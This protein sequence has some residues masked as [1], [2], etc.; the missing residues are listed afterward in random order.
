M[1]QNNPVTLAFGLLLMALFLVLLFVF[2]VRQT[3]VAV[4][5]TFGKA[6]RPITEPGLNFKWPW[7]IQKVTKLD[8]RVQNFEGKFE[9]TLTADGR[10]LLIMVYVGWTIAD[11]GLFYSRFAGGSITEAERTLEGLVRSAKNAAVGRQPFAA[12]ISTEG[13]GE[14]FTAVELEILA[15]IQKDA[16][17]RYGMD[18][19]LLGIKRLGLPESVTEKVFE[20]MRAE[21]SKEVERLRAEGTEEAIKIK[22]AADLDRDRILA[23]ADAQATR[24]RGEGDAEAAKS[25]AVFQQNPELALLIL[26]L[27]ALETTLADRATLLLDPRTPPFDLLQQGGVSTPSA[28]TSSPRLPGIQP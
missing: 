15:A 24:T 8:R 20:R 27:N 19:R 9:E 6:T 13:A 14:R 16:L 1:K 4:V 23:E 12:F 2:Q 11:P 7:P 21:R 17:S 22:S 10:N 3:E 18:V 5:T 25:F 26:K 28:A